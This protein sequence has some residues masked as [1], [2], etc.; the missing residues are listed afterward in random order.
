[1][2]QYE[3]TLTDDHENR[4][5]VEKHMPEFLAT[6]DTFPYPIQRADAIRYLWLYVNGGAWCDLDMIITGD[7]EPA[8]ERAIARSKDPSKVQV[9]LIRSGSWT[10]NAINYLMFSRPGWEGWKVL[11]RSMMRPTP[12]YMNIS[13]HWTVMNTTGPIALDRIVKQWEKTHPGEI[14][15]LPSELV[16]PRVECD[17]PACQ[18]RSSCDRDAN[19]I[20]NIDGMSWASWDSYFLLWFTCH[21][22]SF[23]GWLLVIIG[24]V[25][26]LIGFVLAIKFGLVGLAMFIIGDGI[27]VGGLVA[28]SR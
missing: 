27:L 1:M 10:G 22:K 24:L 26:M 3:Y 11:L 9:V 25:L 23:V 6:Y 21:G 5:F 8:V 17:S 7:L 14:A 15:Y 20:Q 2:P 4:A 28:F 18:R 12:W 13:K 16:T 19:L